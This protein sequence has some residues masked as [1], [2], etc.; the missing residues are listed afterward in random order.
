MSVIDIA[1]IAD[2]VVAA[3]QTELGED[4]LMDFVHRVL[5]VE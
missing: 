5:V 2:E 1:V 4:P 3:L